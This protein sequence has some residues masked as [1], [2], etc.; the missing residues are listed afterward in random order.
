MLRRSSRCVVP[1]AASLG[2]TPRMPALW[3][4]Q[5]LPNAGCWG[6][7]R[8]LLPRRCRGCSQ[9]FSVRTGTVF[10]DSRVPL[11]H[12]CYAFWRASTSKKA[13]SALR[14]KRQ[15]GLSYKSALFLLHRIRYAMEVRT[16]PIADVSARTLKAAIREDVVASARILTDEFTS[17]QGIGSEFASGHQTVN[18]SDSEFARPSGWTGSPLRSHLLGLP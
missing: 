9:Q 12:W 15:T 1:R 16:R 7:A 14:I 6:R 4:Y 13:V 5:R 3:R 8:E 10:E 18:R 17:Y 2:R 11:R